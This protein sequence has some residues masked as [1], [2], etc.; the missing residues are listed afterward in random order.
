MVSA[1]KDRGRQNLQMKSYETSDYVGNVNKPIDMNAIKL[2]I[3]E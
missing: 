2:F 1:S 3:A